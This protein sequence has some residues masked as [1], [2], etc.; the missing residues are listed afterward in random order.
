[1]MYLSQESRRGISSLGVKLGLWFKNLV[2][3]LKGCEPPMLEVIS[4][5]LLAECS[6]KDSLLAGV[7]SETRRSVTKKYDMINWTYK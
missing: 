6:L 5:L 1:M 4:L 3:L 7:E 2:N